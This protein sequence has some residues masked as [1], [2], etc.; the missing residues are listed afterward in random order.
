MQI[1]DEEKKLS[2]NKE[3]NYELRIPE[4]TKTSTLMTK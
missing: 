2:N 3:T 1:N 4:K